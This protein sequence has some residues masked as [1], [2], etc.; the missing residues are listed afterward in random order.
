MTGQSKKQSDLDSLIN[1]TAVHEMAKMI[2]MSMVN[3]SGDLASLGDCSIPPLQIPDQFTISPEE[4]ECI[5]SRINCPKA[6]E[7]DGIM[8]SFL[9][10]FAAILSEP[11]SGIFN[12][13]IQEG[14]VPTIWKKADEVPVPKT[15]PPVN[16]NDLRRISLTPTISKGLESFV[17]EWMLE[18][19]GDKFDE[20]RFGG[21]RGRSTRTDRPLAYL[22]SGT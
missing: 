9:R 6:P 11:V 18:A 1:N 19:I 17:A 22:A 16:I 2:S 20:K 14:Q 21:L 13:S 5:L 8:N 12:Q 10:D 15:R 3:V 7:P 4:V